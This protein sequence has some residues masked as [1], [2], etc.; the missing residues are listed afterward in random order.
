MV[1][2]FISIFWL[3]INVFGHIR[4]KNLADLFKYVRGCL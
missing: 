2:P 4:E 3:E 1:Y